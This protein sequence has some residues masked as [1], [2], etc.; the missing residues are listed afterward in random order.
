MIWYHGRVKTCQG[1]HTFR[2]FD[3]QTSANG[4]MECIPP[5]LVKDEA[6]FGTGQL[7]KF[8]EDLF[9]TTDRRWLIPTA[10]VSLTNLV[11]EQITPEEELPLRLTA[12]THCLVVDLDRRLTAGDDLPTLPPWHVQENK[13]RAARYALDAIVILDDRNRER[14]VTEDLDDL[15]EHLTPV[16]KRLGCE[17]ELRSIDANLLLVAGRGDIIVTPSCTQA[18]LAHAISPDKSLIEVPGGHM[19][20]LGGSRAPRET[21]PQV[22]DWLAQRSH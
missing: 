17:A 5:L 12:L 16:A 20:I 13:W 6:V 8:A 10:E 14:L 3:T 7:P 11:R 21:W 4:Y 1:R 19:G 9:R 18:L 2:D 15:L 22:A